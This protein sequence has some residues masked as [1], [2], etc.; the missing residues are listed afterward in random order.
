M[1]IKSVCF[2]DQCT[3]QYIEYVTDKHDEK[4]YNKGLFNA[5]SDQFCLHPFA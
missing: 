4:W 2:M 3:G 5:M 1:K